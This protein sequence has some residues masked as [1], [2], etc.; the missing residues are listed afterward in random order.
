MRHASCRTAVFA[1]ILGWAALAAPAAPLGAPPPP[2]AAVPDKGEPPYGIDKRV[3]WTHSHVVGSPNPPPPYHIV[4]VFPKLTFNQPLYVVTEPG[5]DDMLVVSHDGGYEG[6]GRIVRLKNKA[7]AEKT[8]PFLEINRIVYGVTFH[9]DYAKNGYLYVGSNGPDEEK[10][11]KQDRVSRFT[12]ERKPPYRCDPKSEVVILEWASNGHNGGDLGFGPD[13]YLYVT[14]GD[15]TSDSDGDLRGQDLTHLTAKVL[16]LD[17]DHP[18]D[19]VGAGLPRPYSVP[20][21][22][23]FVDRKGVCPETW[24]YGFRNPWRMTFDRKSGRLWVGQNGQDLWE[25]AYVVHK[26]DNCGWSVNEGSHPFQPDRAH[27]P[28]P[29]VMPAVEHHHSEFRSLTGGVVYYGSKYP[30]LDGAYI[31]GDYSTGAIWAARHDG[32]KTLSDRELADSRL[33]IVGFGIDPDGEPLIVDHAGGLYTLEPTVTERTKTPFPSRLSETGVFISVKG[34]QVDPGL[35]PYDVNAPLWSDG[36]L[37]ERYI[38]LTGDGQIEFTTW[39]GWNFPEGTVLVKTFSLNLLEGDAS[40]RRRIETRLLTKQNGQWQGYSYLWN[41]EQTD[42]DL[43][44]AAGIDRIY[45]IRDLD[46]LGG[47][48]KQTWHYPS[49]AECMVCHSRA[50]NWVLGLTEMQMNKVHDYD[51]VKDEQLRTLEHLGVFHVNC[52]DH[53]VEAKRR[54]GD[55]LAAIHVLKDV[56]GDVAAV[57]RSLSPAPVRDLL[58]AAGRTASNLSAALAPKQVEPLQP[59]ED[60]LRKTPLYTTSLPKRPGEYRRLA[61]PADAKADLD[62]RARSYLQ[63]NCAQCHVAAGGGNSLINLEFTTARKE[64]HLYGAPPQHQAFGVQD[65]LLIAPGEPDRSVLLQRIARRGQNQ[66][67]PLAT[68]EVDREAVRMLR[69]WITGMK[70]E[71]R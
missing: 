3:L 13:G 34:H 59:L 64:A 47:P 23:P 19:A 65:A 2:M 40:S 17:V 27:G 9:P 38:G 68:S 48:R 39:R 5:T 28:D 53:V 30:E 56:G 51:G 18:A 43:V 14:S 44:P 24:A 36:A 7:D 57:P 1:A 12:V 25:Q 45:E 10:V 32:V 33:Q 8:E 11:K 55:C 22:N 60:F 54:M 4:R 42:A 35:I 16:R 71:E 37:K 61:D 31:Y 49:R 41:D 66:M 70:A 69:E 6:P 46:K 26:G 58:D 50:A 52:L 63:A 21:D 67:P 29:I 15:G 20:K 62:S